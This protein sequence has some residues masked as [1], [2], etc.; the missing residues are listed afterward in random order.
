MQET[1]A[2]AKKSP[3]KPSLRV[4]PYRCGGDTGKTNEGFCL[5]KW[6]L[7]S[8]QTIRI[9][10]SVYFYDS[11]AKNESQEKSQNYDKEMEKRLIFATTRGIIISE[12]VW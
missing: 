3:Q 6:T 1:S 11:T 12:V 9:D 7:P 4:S 5:G 10:L 8:T 2:F